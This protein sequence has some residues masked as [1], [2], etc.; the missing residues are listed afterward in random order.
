M[1]CN[2]YSFPNF[3]HWKLPSVLDHV[4]I[5]LES[6]S[7]MARALIVRR[8]IRRDLQWGCLLI[9]G[10][11]NKLIRCY[12][13]GRFPFI[14]AIKLDTIVWLNFILLPDDVMTW[15]PFTPYWP[16]CEEI[17]HVR[18]SWLSFNVTLMGGAALRHKVWRKR[19][20][21]HWISIIPTNKANVDAVLFNNEESFV[22]YDS[23]TDIMT[24]K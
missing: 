18:P 23:S 1:F 5:S 10:P 19:G 9:N 16:F 13:P 7:N 6:F 12:M 4:R 8:D 21:C 22:K 17:P 11:F 20:F 2:F 15:N 3:G 24:C 14:K